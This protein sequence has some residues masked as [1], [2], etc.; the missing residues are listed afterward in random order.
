MPA[1]VQ[2]VITV[3]LEGMMGSMGASQMSM[4]LLNELLPAWALGAIKINMMPVMKIIKGV[5]LRNFI[6]YQPPDLLGRV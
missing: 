5:N 6:R 1:W 4:L 3:G 2:L